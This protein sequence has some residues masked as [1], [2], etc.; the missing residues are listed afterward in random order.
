[1]FGDKFESEDLER[2]K[3]RCS[4]KRTGDEQ[5]GSGVH[6]NRLVQ[7]CRRR[8]AFILFAEGRIET[9]E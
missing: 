6:M 2:K 7:S 9:R 8:L 4:G 1:M 3:P 5:D